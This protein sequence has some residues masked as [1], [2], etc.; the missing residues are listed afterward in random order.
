MSELH[1]AVKQSDLARVKLLIEHGLD[2]NAQDKKRGTPLLLA[3]SSG[4]TAAAALLIEHGA[5]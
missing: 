5:D 2:V 1:D 3:A 4:D